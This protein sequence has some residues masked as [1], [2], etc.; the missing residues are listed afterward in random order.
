MPDTR[1]L[2]EQLKDPKQANKALNGLMQVTASHELN[3]TLDNDEALLRAIVDVVQYERGKAVEIENLEDLLPEKAWV[4]LKK[5]PSFPS[6]CI[7]ALHAVL[8]IF[9][10][11]SFVAANLRPMTQEPNVMRLLIDC[12]YLE[13]NADLLAHAVF[14]LVNLAP[15]MD[16]TG[17]KLLADQLFLDTAN[18]LNKLGWGGLQFARQ[19]DDSHQ[20]SVEKEVLWGASRDYVNQVWQVFAGLR[21]TI[22]SPKT[23]RTVLMM[24]TDWINALLEHRDPSVDLPSMYDVLSVIPDDVMQR[25]VDFLWVPRLGPDALDYVNPITNVVS[26]V[27]TLKLFMGYDAT[28]DTELRDRAL[29]VLQQLLELGLSIPV[30]PRFYN[31]ILPCLTTKV[32]RADAQVLAIGILKTLGKKKEHRDGL[33]YAQERLVELSSKDARVA[34]LALGDLFFEKH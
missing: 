16:V 34:Q 20:V 26:R 33:V 8:V 5:I 22:L 19:L 17:Q 24:T 15:V 31:A 13:Q 28:V 2:V 30:T 3:F 18:E 27:S 32:G 14:T 11:L 23:P 9:R 10:N 7:P 21:H 1:V 6:S 29:E 25:L 4:D 12:L